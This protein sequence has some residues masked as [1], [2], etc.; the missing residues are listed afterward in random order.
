MN[1]VAL[2]CMVSLFSFIVKGSATTAECSLH[3]FQRVPRC[4]AALFCISSLS[5]YFVAAFCQLETWRSQ[6]QCP[7]VRKFRHGVMLVSLCLCRFL[8][9]SCLCLCK[10]LLLHRNICLNSSQVT[11][12]PL[13]P[14]NEGS[15]NLCRNEIDH[16]SGLQQSSHIQVF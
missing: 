10:F 2:T 3:V 14:S 5:P 13:K 15:L 4:L 12:F 8:C 16:A 7:D 11:A 6:N 9:V 1:T